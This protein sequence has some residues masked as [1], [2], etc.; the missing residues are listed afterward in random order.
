MIIMNETYKQN[1]NLDFAKAVFE[2][3]VS[4]SCEHGNLYCRICDG[5]KGKDRRYYY[6][7]QAKINERSRARYRQQKQ[8][9]LTHL[10]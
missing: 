10:Y 8:R 1:K 7:N 4:L 9:L 3:I 2:N 5:R 6:I